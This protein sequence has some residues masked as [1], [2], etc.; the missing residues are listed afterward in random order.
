MASSPTRRRVPPTVATKC[1]SQKIGYATRADA[2]DAAEHTMDAGRVK[3]GCHIMPYL[4]DRCGEWH[5][6]NQ[7]IVP[8]PRQYLET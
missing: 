7:I 4:C 3:P 5:V 1:E 2:L 8:I 6:A